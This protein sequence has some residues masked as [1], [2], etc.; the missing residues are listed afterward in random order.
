MKL[1][2]IRISFSGV[3][4]KESIYEMAQEAIKLGAKWDRDVSS[5]TN[6]LVKGMDYIEKKDEQFFEKN[7]RLKYEYNVEQAKGLG[8][9]I[10]SENDFYKL[11]KE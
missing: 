9:K 11:I 10:I 5:D 2:N 4:E 6:I 3:M 8:T 7:S 1:E